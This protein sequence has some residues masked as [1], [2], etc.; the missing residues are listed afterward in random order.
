MNKEINHEETRSLLRRW[1]D[2]ATSPGEERRLMELL[3][4]PEGVP[5]DLE[6]DARLL[7]GLG[8]A[9]GED[10][11]MPEAV[12]R[13]LDEALRDEVSAEF[14]RRRKRRFRRIMLSCGVAASLLGVWTGVRILSVVTGD[15]AGPSPGIAREAMA[16]SAGA[17]M[18][19]EGILIS[20]SDTLL[21]EVAP[22]SAPRK[23]RN[24]VGTTLSRGAKP[25]RTHH[26]EQ[27]LPEDTYLYL[28]PEEEAELVAMNYRVIDNQYEAE[29]MVNSIVGRL[30]GNIVEEVSR[31][32][33]MQ[34]DYQR[35]MT[36]FYN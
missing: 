2:G 20:P 27:A 31:M 28:S 1:Y 15:G 22:P 9:A 19:K 32:E 29:M 21:T 30:E 16:V 12:S 23:E 33:S 34:A 10:V 13:R 25:I 36:K 7:L 18:E 11:S 6:A 14:T 8:E 4:S 26:P 17:G 35:E 5:P 3:S 24:S